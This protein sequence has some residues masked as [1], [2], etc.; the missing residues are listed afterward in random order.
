[1][2]PAAVL[3]LPLVAAVVCGG[4][5]P[6]PSPPTSAG[7]IAVSNGLHLHYEVHGTGPDTVVVLHGGPGLQMGYLVGDWRPLESGRTLIYYDQRGRGRSEAVKDTMLLTAANDVTDLE[8]VRAH[9]SI[10][11]MTL[12][13]HHWGAAIA[14]LYAR[15]YPEHVARLLLVSPS[16]PKSIYV[17]H[18]ATLP[19]DNV[20]TA[21]FLKSNAAGE[22]TL[23][24]RGFCR[25][26]WGFVFSPVEVTEPRLVRRL[27]GPMCDAPDPQLR[28]MFLT[29]HLIIN[30]IHGLNLKDTLAT[31][32]VPALILQGHGDVSLMD[33]ADAWTLWLRHARMVE[34]PEPTLFPWLGDRSRFLADATAFLDGGWPADAHAA[35][36]PSALSAAHAD[37]MARP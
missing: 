24:P 12:A 30:S 8:A 1:M 25:R 27:A 14:A 34:L 20:A 10:G 37:S 32:E 13:A 5:S 19:N 3:V 28:T 18:A 17:F 33:A 15:R 9:F 21:K 23:D 22:D 36:L 26:Y 4:C 2:R 35:T 7:E 31:I 16:F 11:R 6:R 29:T